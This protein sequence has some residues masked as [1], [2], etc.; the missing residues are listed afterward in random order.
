MNFMKNNP[1]YAIKSIT[2]VYD[3]SKVS[4]GYFLLTFGSD[5]TPFKLS[6]VPFL[7]Q[8]VREDENLFAYLKKTVKDKTV[9]DAIFDLYDL[10]FPVD[11]WVIDHIE[12]AKESVTPDMFNALV[13]FYN[14]IKDFNNDPSG[15]YNV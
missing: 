1:E 14:F 6:F 2:P 12:K 8:R 7:E 9:S 4:G 15:S 13:Q 10:G 11:E 5:S 3:Y